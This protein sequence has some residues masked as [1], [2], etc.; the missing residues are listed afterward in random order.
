MEWIIMADPISAISL[1]IPPATLTPTKYS[2]C[3]LE[4]IMAEWKVRTMA[5][6]F[7]GNFQVMAKDKK[8]SSAILVVLALMALRALIT[9]CFKG[10][11]DKMDF[12]SSAFLT[13]ID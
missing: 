9:R 2:K 1:S 5:L 13:R 10:K 11:M 6:P 7:S 12:L 3:S 8:G 4:P